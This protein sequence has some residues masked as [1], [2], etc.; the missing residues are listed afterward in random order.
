L[1][2]VVVGVVEEEALQALLRAVAYAQILLLKEAQYFECQ[3]LR[4]VAAPA[5]LAIRFF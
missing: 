4:L 2:L 1:V 3:F 5:P